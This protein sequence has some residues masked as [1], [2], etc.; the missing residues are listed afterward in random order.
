ML[1]SRNEKEDDD[2]TPLSAR[3]ILLESQNTHYLPQEDQ[4]LPPPL[5]LIF[6]F[7]RTHSSTVLRARFLFPG[8]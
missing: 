8:N 7:H 1:S 4:H 5:P 6:G 2:K 3:Y